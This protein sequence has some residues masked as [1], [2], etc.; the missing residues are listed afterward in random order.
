VI[1]FGIGLEDGLEDGLLLLEQAL[2]SIEQL[3]RFLRIADEGFE[4]TTAEVVLRN[5]D[6]AM[7]LAKER[8]KDRVELF[9]E[10]MHVTAFERLELKACQGSMGSLEGRKVR[11][12]MRGRKAHLDR[13]ARKVRRGR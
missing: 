10:A 8:G 12:E 4:G 7:Y 13:M 6:M 2:Q 11:K 9:E 1:G 5:A 3:L